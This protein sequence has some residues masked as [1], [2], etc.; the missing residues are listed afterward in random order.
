MVGSQKNGDDYEIVD[1]KM[2]TPKFRALTTEIENKTH[3]IVND[4]I[5]R[6]KLFKQLDDQLKVQINDVIPKI[7]DGDKKIEKK[8]R[9]E[10]L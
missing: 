9:K 7:E 10:E 6:E 8:E 5:A 2:F 1:E 4:K 3:H